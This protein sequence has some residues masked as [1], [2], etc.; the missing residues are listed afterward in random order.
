MVEPVDGAVGALSK[1][2]LQT[3]VYGVLASIGQTA[4]P[5]EDTTIA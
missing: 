1:P 5:G 2:Q 3:L 4:T